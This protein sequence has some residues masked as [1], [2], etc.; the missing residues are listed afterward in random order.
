MAL[1]LVLAAGLTGAYLYSQSGGSAPRFRTAPVSR[2]PVTASI[3][4][5]GNLN[6]V[7]TVQVGSQVSGQVRELFAD[8]NSE[9]KRGQLIARIDPA[10]FEAKV[11]QVRLDGID[12]E[13]DDLRVAL[14]EFGLEP[15]H[16]AQLR[17]AHRG[18]VLRV[19]KQHS[20]RLPEPLVKADAAFG[21]FSFEVGS[22]VA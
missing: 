22:D 11:A 20:P 12:A 16:V 7:I 21:R 1:V 9:V 10:T 6:A 18:E 15:G 13:A 4:T 19:R 17:G 8:F 3:A 2:G 5:T 14:V